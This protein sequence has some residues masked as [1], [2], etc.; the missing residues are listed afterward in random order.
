MS[1]ENAEHRVLVPSAALFV[2]IPDLFVHR[3]LV[4]RFAGVVQGSDKR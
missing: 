4:F 1:G 3:A 2:P